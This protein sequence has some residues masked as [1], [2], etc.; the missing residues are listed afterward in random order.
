[1]RLAEADLDKMIYFISDL[2]LGHP[3]VIGM[4]NRPFQNIEEMNQVLIRNY[5][6]IV[7]KNDMHFA[8]MIIE[9]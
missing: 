7:H 6:N 3:Q 4:Q 2:H 9:S 5:N 1:M 8:L